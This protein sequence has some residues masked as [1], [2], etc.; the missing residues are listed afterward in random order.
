MT[1]GA[2][3]TSVR[4][5]ALPPLHVHCFSPLRHVKGVS[6]QEGHGSSSFRSPANRRLCPSRV[7]KLRP[8]HSRS[9]QTNA[10]DL[11]IPPPIIGG[12]LRDNQQALDAVFDET[13]VPL[14][15]R[16]ASEVD[17]ALDGGVVVFD[18]SHWGRF[19]VVG[20][21]RLQFLHGQST[22]E[23]KALRPGQGCDTVFVTPTAR[24][25]DLA[26]AYAQETGVFVVVSP[27]M[28]G[29]IISRLDR[30]IFRGDNV[31]LQ[32]MDGKCCLLSLLGPKSR[33]LLEELKAVGLPADAYASHT[34]LDFDG[35]PV[36][37]AVGSGLTRDGYTLIADE[38]VAG[39]LW[40]VLVARGAVPAGEEEWERARVLVGRPKP[41]AE[42]TED[43]N[44]LEAGLYSAVSVDK[45]CYVGQET[46]SKVHNNDAV[47]Q[48]LWG[49][50]LSQPCELGARIQR[51]SKRLGQLTSV[52]QTLGGDHFGLGY[53]RCREGGAQ[54]DLEGLDVTVG[55][56]EAKVKSIPYATRAFEGQEL[57]DE[58][59]ED[60]ESGTKEGML[61]RESE[62]DQEAA[63][64][65]R[66][67]AMQERLA[68]WKAQEGKPMQ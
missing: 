55:G 26:T 19:R 16:N 64:Q 54:V 17:A 11:D 21:G 37:V 14:S 61:S 45:G 67:K 42:L 4:V 3:G 36:M 5:F 12:D 2:V 58:R 27:G 24:T 7:P 47:K 56:V 9:L 63:K 60:V 65:E 41:G 57:S 40:N 43:Y 25:I 15:F 48:Q 62:E 49:L 53:L 44:P 46:L 51:G 66:L 23:F 13:G 50:E 39:E 59:T 6:S 32:D 28:A 34:L 30:Y 8:G 52:T 38:A 31:E 29:S 35:K 22:N 18:R 1:A 33:E 68:A 20:S 10:N